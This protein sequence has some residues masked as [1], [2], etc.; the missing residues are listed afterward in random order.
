MA[1][2][3]RV[4][5]GEIRGSEKMDSE[6]CILLKEE[7]RITEDLSV[8]CMD[9]LALSEASGRAAEI[10]GWVVRDLKSDLIE[11]KVEYKPTR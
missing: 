2:R 4:S 6:K 7:V 8:Y 3:R 10:G 1:I 11:E 5:Y 9:D